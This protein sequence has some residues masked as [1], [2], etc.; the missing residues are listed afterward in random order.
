MTS[1]FACGSRLL[2]AAARHRQPRQPHRSTASGQNERVDHPAVGTKYPT[3]SGCLACVMTTHHATH[4]IL[5]EVRYDNS[6]RP[7]RA[8]H[9]PRPTWR[10]PHPTRPP[11]LIHREIRTLSPATRNASHRTIIEDLDVINDE[12]AAWQTTEST[13]TGASQLATLTP[14]DAPEPKSSHL[15]PNR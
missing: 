8:P 15:Y 3:P 11:G 9:G 12:L 4:R 13:P 10:P 14:M 5:Y 7:P 6:H 1:I 2:A